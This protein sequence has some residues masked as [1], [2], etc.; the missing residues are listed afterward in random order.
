MASSYVVGVYLTDREFG[1]PEE[2]GWWY[3]TG[4]LVRPIRVFKSERSAYAYSNRLNARLQS[5][6]IGPNVGR[7]SKSSVLSEGEYEARVHE[8]C[9]PSYFPEV[10]PRYE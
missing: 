10:R 2:G 8:G 5:R 7:R 1:G 4:D 3:D 9:C 6:V